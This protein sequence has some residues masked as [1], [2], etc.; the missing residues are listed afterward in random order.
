MTFFL[1]DLAALVLGTLIIPCIAVLPC[2]ALLEALERAGFAAGRGWQ[3]LGWALL[4]AFSVVPV[5]DAS[6]IRLAGV[7]AAIAIRAML[8][9]ISIRGVT[10]WAKDL[11]TP[12]RALVALG[13][14]WWIV[15]AISY[16]DFD[17]AGGLYQSLVAVDLVKHAA[18][19]EALAHHGLPLRDMFFAR[20]QSS[21]YYF[22][23][24][25]LPA[26]LHLALGSIV[27]ARMAFA[28]SLLWA[29]LA[30]PALIW[31]IAADAGIIRLNRER[32]FLVTASWLC[33]VAG[34]GLPCVLIEYGVDGKIAPQVELWTEEVRFALTSVIWVPHHIMALIACWTGALFLHRT[35]LRTARA[36]WRSASLLIVAAG[37]SFASAFGLSIWI[38][39]TAIPIFFCWAAIHLL[40][41]DYRMPVA[42]AAAGAVAAIISVPQIL[43]ILN[44]R[45]G[46]VFPI[47]FTIR[48][49]T[50]W[51]QLAAPSNLVLA[52]FLLSTLPLAYAIQ[53][54]YFALGTHLF[55]RLHPRKSR[56]QN[57]LRSLLVVSAIISLIIASFFRSTIINNDLGIR[58][59]CFAQFSAMIWTTGVLHALPPRDSHRATL[60]VL[61]SLGLLGNVWDLV[62]LRILRAPYVPAR[63]LKINTAPAT[64]LAA[65]QA[66]E[67]AAAHIDDNAVIQHNPGLQHRIF[68]FGLYGRQRPTVADVE[69]NLFGASRQEVMQRMNALW[70]VFNVSHPVADVQATARRLGIDFLL[71]TDQDPV[72]KLQGRLPFDAACVYGNAHVCILPTKAAT[73]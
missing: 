67:W 6:V 26:E 37:L 54:G 50:Y 23:Y 38:T 13:A 47:A 5:L 8:A 69:A 52:L 45:S 27:D 24:Y 72:W 19:T 64:D 3:R 70:P 51:S 46:E 63:G 59:I 55:L 31:R 15:V 62:G 41:R 25:T 32:R 42:L 1:H 60:G 12:P 65:R 14:L 44:G 30:V 20:P 73:P 58:A 61:L 49:F 2:F 22:Y 35:D 36:R 16:L 71:F 40:R 28:S 21:G 17:W 4:L 10:V 68:D 29:G 56:H 34:A 66:Y 48:S 43:D 53:F 11:S 9:V 7:P 33:F 57:S 39:V 18:V